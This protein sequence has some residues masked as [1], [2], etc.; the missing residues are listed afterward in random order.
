MKRQEVAAIEIVLLAAGKPA[1][2]LLVAGDGSIQR[3][4]DG[5]IPSGD[6]D[7]Y[8]GHTEEP[9]FQRLHACIRDEWLQRPGA[10]VAEELPGDEIVLTIRFLRAPE[11]GV[12]IQ[13]RYG[14]ESDGPPAEVRDFLETA[15]DLTDSWYADQRMLVLL[16]NEPWSRLP[17]EEG[18]R[19]FRLEWLLLDKSKPFA[20]A[21]TDRAIHLLKRKRFA[22]GYPWTFRTFA[23]SRVLEVRRRRVMP[24]P[25]YL[26]ALL[27]LVVGGATTYWMVQPEHWGS[28]GKVSLYPIALLIAG[29]VIPFVARGR[30][31]FAILAVDGRFSWKPPLFLGRKNRQA[32]RESQERLLV[33]FRER[34]VKVSP[35]PL[36][37]E[38][39]PNAFGGREDL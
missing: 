23:L 32:I 36:P 16:Q 10:Y 3:M 9:L 15:L 26:L 2:L 20:M 27:L 18:E 21:V 19:I 6:P 17:L 24:W 11:D 33:F 13:Y 28:G 29:L 8:R 7:G 12:G 22:A 39:V 25:A 14:S 34:G 31:R 1:L 38:A 35:E 4:G 5:S 37:R 30:H